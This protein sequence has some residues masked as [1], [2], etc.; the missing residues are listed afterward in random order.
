MEQSGNRVN[1]KSEV[2]RDRVVIVKIIGSDKGQRGN[3]VILCTIPEF[4]C[5]D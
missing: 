3:S 4:F 1:K 5:R 2:I